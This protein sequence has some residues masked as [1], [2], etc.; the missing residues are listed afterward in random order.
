MP[1]S[2]MP[3]PSAEASAKATTVTKM[4][5]PMPLATVANT[6]RVEAV[7]GDIDAGRDGD[8]DRGGQP[9]GEVLFGGGTGGRQHQADTRERIIAA[10]APCHLLLAGRTMPPAWEMRRSR[11]KRPAFYCA[12]L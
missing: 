3:R 1:I 2:A 7:G 4:V 11:R 8:Q 12:G 9:V 5:M 6:W 10:I